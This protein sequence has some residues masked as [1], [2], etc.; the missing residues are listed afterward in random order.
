MPTYHSAFHEIKYDD[1]GK[2]SKMWKWAEYK[3]SRLPLREKVTLYAKI[4]D[5]DITDLDDRL[6]VLF[7][8]PNIFEELSVYLTHRQLE[9]LKMMSY[10]CTHMEICQE[11]G[12]KNRSS[13]SAILK[14]VREEIKDLMRT[15]QEV[16]EDLIKLVNG[17]KN[18]DSTRNRGGKEGT[19]LPG[20][21]KENSVLQGQGEGEGATT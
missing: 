10:G 17:G 18:A 5:R 19:S 21:G 16:E 14:D 15:D 11:F 12:Y 20:K 4:Y 3:L 13:I 2:K 7:K 1:F 8:I 9:V 6:D